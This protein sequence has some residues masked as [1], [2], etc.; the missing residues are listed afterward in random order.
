MTFLATLVLSVLDGQTPV[1][2]CS[3]FFMFLTGVVLQ[4]YPNRE[5]YKQAISSEIS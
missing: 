2:F 4:A 1:Q 5:G 3:T